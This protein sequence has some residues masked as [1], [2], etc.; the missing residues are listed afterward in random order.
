MNKG[1]KFQFDF[2]WILFGRT[3]SATNFDKSKVWNRFS[4]TVLEIEIINGKR[5]K[6]TVQN[7]SFY[8]EIKMLLYLFAFN[9]RN[10]CIKYR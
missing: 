7:S 5:L 10:D 1:I 4:V 3:H 8:I 6:K 9:D 2:K